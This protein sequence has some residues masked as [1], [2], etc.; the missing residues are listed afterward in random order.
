MALADAGRSGCLLVVE[1]EAF[2]GLGLDLGILLMTLPS[3]YPVVSFSE[4]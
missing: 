4:P 3:Q 1:E 2:P